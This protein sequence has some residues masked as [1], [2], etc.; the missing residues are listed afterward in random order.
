MEPILT[1]DMMAPLVKEWWTRT[2]MVEDIC[3]AYIGMGRAVVA[4]VEEAGEKPTDDVLDAIDI[5]EELLGM[6]EDDDSSLGEKDADDVIDACDDITDYI[7]EVTGGIYHIGVSPFE[8]ASGG[9]WL[10]GDLEDD[11]DDEDREYII[12]G[13]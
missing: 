8:T 11:E 9:I 7:D 6:M 5:L 13:D 1:P 10:I 12:V 3:E 2:M 4:L